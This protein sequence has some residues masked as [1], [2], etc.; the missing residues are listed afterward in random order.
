[1]KALIDAPI[2]ENSPDPEAVPF[3]PKK[4]SDIQAEIELLRDIRHRLDC[5][6]KTLP[7]ICCYTF[8]NTHDS[9]C[10]L[11]SSVNTEYVAG[12]FSDSI[13]KLWKVDSSKPNEPGISNNNNSGTTY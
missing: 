9:L 8:H 7:S 11:K 13:I 5:D 3:P 2:D 6:D 12:G 4:L 10:C 1:V